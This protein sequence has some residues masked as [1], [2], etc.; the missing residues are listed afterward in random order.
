MSIYFE[1]CYLSEPNSFQKKAG[2][3]IDGWQLGEYFIEL[4][5]LLGKSTFKNAKLY[6]PD[7]GQPRRKT[8]KMLKR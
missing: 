6:G 8:V 5:K 1:N 4:H 3:F 2:I 7:V